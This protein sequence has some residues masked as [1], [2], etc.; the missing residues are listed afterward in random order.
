[1]LQNF[2]ATRY[3][4]LKYIKNRYISTLLDLSSNEILKGIYIKE[5]LKTN[6]DKIIIA[7]KGELIKSNNGKVL[8]IHL[9]KLYIKLIKTHVERNS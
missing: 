1:M 8:V 3:A 5:R 7:K 6:E 4:K 2:V 9:W